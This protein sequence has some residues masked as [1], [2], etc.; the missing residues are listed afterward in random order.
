MVRNTIKNIK[1]LYGLFLIPPIPE[2]LFEN[3]QYYA[4]AYGAIKDLD[5]FNQ[6]TTYYKEVLPDGDE[7]DFT[8][9]PFDLTHLISQNHIKGDPAIS[10]LEGLYK[11]AGLNLFLNIAGVKEH[12]TE[13]LVDS[14]VSKFG[15]FGLS[16]IQYPKD[17]I[18]EYISTVLSI[19]LL[20]R[21]NDINQY[22]SQGHKNN[23]ARNEIADLVGN[24]WDEIINESF[25]VLDSLG[26]GK[27]IKNELE[28]LTRKLVK[29]DFSNPYDE[30]YKQFTC[31]SANNFYVAVNDNVQSASN[32]VIDRI[33]EYN[34]KILNETENILF[35]KTSLE[36]F[37]N[38]IDDTLNYWK[39]LE[40][41]SI[42]ANWEVI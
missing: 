22:I 10:T 33:F 42:P 3:A 6:S 38:Y 40:I 1:E 32:I 31:R 20:N 7:V 23:I 5:Y 13:R 14:P 2:D 34:S 29:G 41:S 17:Q 8:E 26:G 36:Y 15:T 25:N 35:A 30:L 16:A 37:S 27:T 11:M 4:N 19:D 18:Q 21:W 9:P 12:R 28:L 39:R 24:T